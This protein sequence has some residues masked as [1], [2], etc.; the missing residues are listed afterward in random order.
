MP[1]PLDAAPVRAPP[2]P[3]A[4]AL[5]LRSTANLS[6]RDVSDYQER[7]SIFEE[8]ILGW[9]KDKKE[10]APARRPPGEMIAGRYIIVERIS[11]GG[12]G[13]VYRAQDRLE[14][15]DVALKISM[16][17][18][19]G[20][21]SAW[22]L[23]RQEY[24]AMTTLRHPNLPVV[25][26]CGMT[27]AGEP[28]VV[29]GYIDGSPIRADQP[30]SLPSF[31]SIFIQLL[32]GLSFIHDRGFLHRDVKP[33]N[34]L[35]TLPVAGEEGPRLV[36]LDFGLMERIGMPSAKRLAGTP[37]YMAPEV[38]QGRVL[39]PR[40][41]LYSLGIFAF[42]VLTGRLPFSHPDVREIFRLHQQAP[43]PSI[44]AYNPEVPLPLDVLVGRM[45]AVSAAE[46]PSSAEDVLYELSMM[47]S[48]VR[49]TDCESRRA[50][51]RLGDLVGRD[52]QMG[53]LRGALS[54]AEAG[55]GRCDIVVGVTGSGKSRLLQEV[56]I[57]ALM[58]GFTVTG[59]AIREE[60]RGPY[61]A[62]RSLL[63][64]LV[65]IATDLA[66]VP[67]S[68][69]AL[70][71]ILPEF[72]A[73]GPSAGAAGVPNPAEERGLLIKETVAWLRQ[74]A[75]ARPVLMIADDL[76]WCDESSLLVLKA[77]SQQL[78]EGR[79]AMVCACRSNEVSA[80]SDVDEWLRTEHVQTVETPGFDDDQM[81]QFLDG[82][83]GHH[84][85]GLE[86]VRRLRRA[87]GGSPFF[88]IELLRDLID[89]DRL[90][91]FGGIW[92]AA[93][94]DFVLP[95]TLVQLLGERLARLS[96]EA[97][98]IGLQVAVA[99]GR[100]ELNTM[101]AIISQP[102][103]SVLQA[104]EQ[105]FQFK[106]AETQGEEFVLA[107]DSIREMILQSAQA[108]LRAA[109][110]QR[111]AEYLECKLP[112]DDPNRDVVLGH[113]FARGGD[114]QKGL[115]HLER[116][117]RDSFDREE[118]GVARNLLA[119]A[120]AILEAWPAARDRERRMYEVRRMLLMVCV[121]DAYAEGSVR[122]EQ[123][124]NYILHNGEL[125]WLPILQRI[126]PDPFAFLV[127]LIV[128]VPFRVAVHGRRVVAD[129]LCNLNDLFTAVGAGCN[130]LAAM[131][132]LTTSRRVAARLKAFA[133]T[134]RSLA[135]AVME[136]AQTISK[137]QQLGDLIAGDYDRARKI[138]MSDRTIR[139]MHSYSRIL[140]LGVT[141]Y[142]RAFTEAWAQSPHFE[143]SHRACD[144]F[145][146]LHSNHF[147]L[148]L[149]AQA[150]VE[151]S[152]YSGDVIRADKA[153]AK[154]HEELGC[155][156]GK[157]RQREC[158]VDFAMGQI[159]I[160]S[161]RF[162]RAS[163]RIQ[164]LMRGGP[165]LHTA[166]YSALLSARLKLEWNRL[167]EAMEEAEKAVRMARDPE[168]M[169]RRFEFLA[170]RVVADIHLRMMHP[171]LAL[172][173]AEEMGA[174]GNDPG[175]LSRYF[176][177][178]VLER[179]ALAISFSEP[180]VALAMAEEA[181]AAA[182]GV[183]CP[184]QLAECHTASATI[185]QRGAAAPAQRRAHLQQA[186]EIYQRLG[187]RHQEKNIAAMLNQ[188]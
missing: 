132:R 171:A 66:L 139:F 91:R 67:P 124:Y 9:S 31:F 42:Q 61:Q 83:L 29:M 144:E 173:A 63:K 130:C 27:S 146:R 64:G 123:L 38:I 145:A 85:L 81:S 125:R 88:T 161:G 182:G 28:F 158:L 169:S 126:L 101:A 115:D 49:D 8:T 137:T 50:Y 159:D 148:L 102:E 131:G 150:L 176:F 133:L 96:P 30:L 154:F 105:W 6:R 160:D 149:S 65:P 111:L 141:Y 39:D 151:Q 33:S 178:A 187:N 167:D 43:R 25:S 116:A 147:L 114:R 121:S 46:R 103:A 20:G 19:Y 84:V 62:L 142:V 110:H 73:A 59:V 153:E 127:L 7:S 120:E 18:H 14:S 78:G 170:L 181:L 157:S 23:F 71:L 45:M 47:T 53:H 135:V 156:G 60:H 108:G 98:E 175:H 93:D 186:L 134:R 163:R 16:R 4:S 155:L 41:D 185:L 188:V 129:L 164:R 55:T 24:L 80:G 1:Q 5:G 183:S 140:A 3:V 97:R 54:Q 99:G 57:E 11:T 179:R 48:Q 34:A 72:F 172:A 117:G 113:H 138:L 177:V 174:Y 44:S 36:L 112:Q 152:V 77:V 74:I 119:E 107:H 168:V 89:R 118:H 32:R 95:D 109:C 166:M 58:R 100:L 13:D 94:P 106:L 143:G 165:G 37:A 76:Q 21:E 68:V 40:T 52:A 136:I 69:R 51:L 86:F 184:K 35:L 180:R 128:V 75:S 70:G 104:C 122:G 22:L 12:M 26:D 79:I 92:R 162:D 10:A 56:Q 2:E 15:R 82:L 90:T 17:M 87:T